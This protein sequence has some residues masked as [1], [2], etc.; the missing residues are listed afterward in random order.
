VTETPSKKLRQWLQRRSSAAM[1]RTNRFS[2]KPRLGREMDRSWLVR[3]NRG[4]EG[5]VA[6]STIATL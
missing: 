2:F 5:R 1:L 3:C 6:F 4:L